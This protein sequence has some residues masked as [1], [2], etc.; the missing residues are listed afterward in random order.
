M[1]NLQADYYECS[2]YQHKRFWGQSANPKLQLIIV[3]NILFQRPE[4]RS[5]RQASG[6]LTKFKNDEVLV[7]PVNDKIKVR[8]SNTKNLRVRE[9]LRSIKPSP[10]D[11][12]IKIRTATPTPTRPI[13]ID[14]REDPDLRKGLGSIYRT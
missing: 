2:N 14:Q 1:V 7:G 10:I 6:S 11:E 4:A 5:E 13:E 8:Q 3:N 12:Y 9:I